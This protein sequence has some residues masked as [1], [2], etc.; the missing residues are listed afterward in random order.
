MLVHS[1]TMY[2]YNW[3]A[4][5]QLLS[6]Y[7]SF[8]NLTA[9]MT[10]LPSNI[11]TSMFMLVANQ[12][13]FKADDKVFELLSELEGV[14]QQFN[15][16]TIQRAL[17]NYHS[18]EYLESEKLF[19]Q[20][21]KT[22]PC[23]LD[24]LDTYSNILYVQDK[25]AKLSFLAHLS[26]SIDRFRSET[27]CIVANYYSLKAEHEKAIIYY[28]RALS[29]NRDCLSAWTLMGHEFVELKNSCAAIESYR[30]AVGMCF[31]YLK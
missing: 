16:L 17:I 27:C 23:C 15:F 12:E 6:C 19:D 10:D 11:M 2:P 21:L 13:F 18:L 26:L 14:F 1:I 24:D 4:W 3:G 7:G 20:V 29:L 22:D 25:Q 8:D 5:K 30:R 9:L 31:F 28:R